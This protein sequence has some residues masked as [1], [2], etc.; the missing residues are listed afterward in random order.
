MDLCPKPVLGGSR[1]AT[2]NPLA[3]DINPRLGLSSRFGLYGGLAAGAI[4]DIILDCDHHI[5]QPRPYIQFP[6]TRVLCHHSSNFQY[7]PPGHRSRS[8]TTGLL[9]HDRP[10]RD[11][12]HCRSSALPTLRHTPSL[13]A[14]NIGI[15]L[16]PRISDHRPHP[17]WPS[18]R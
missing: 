11:G 7:N 3:Q 5:D 8:R 18:G 16:Q 17:R 14:C 2:E 13:R 6:F 15:G 10:R 12:R 4:L 9:G 1:L